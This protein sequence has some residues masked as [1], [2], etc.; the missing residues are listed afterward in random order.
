[1]RYLRAADAT[2]DDNLASEGRINVKAS[3]LTGSF[4]L[5]VLQELWR[6]R[7]WLGISYQAP[8]GLYGAMAMALNGTV[9]TNFS[10][11]GKPSTTKATLHQSLPDIIRFAL[12][13]VEARRSAREPNKNPARHYELRVFGGFERWSRFKNQCATQRG[14]SCDLSSPTNIISAYPRNWHDAWNLNG[15]GNYFFSDHWEGYATLGYDSGA[16]PLGMLEASVIDGKQI[17]AQLGG[18]YYLGTRAAFSIAYTYSY[19]LPRDSSG[20]SRLDQVPSGSPLK[21]P[22]GDGKYTQWV[23]LFNAFLEVFFDGG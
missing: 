2:L 10:K 4:G 3:G 11:D 14:A 20:K 18:R 8:P 21:V 17:S 22:T 5:G 9:D 1:M 16:I 7:L 15:G 19:W 13:Y 23:G 6:E 12:R